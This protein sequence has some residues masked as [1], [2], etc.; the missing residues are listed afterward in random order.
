M[1]ATSSVAYWLR[2][3]SA[4]LAYRGAIFKSAQSAK[5]ALVL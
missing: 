4:L 5:E 2:I 1:K 3:F